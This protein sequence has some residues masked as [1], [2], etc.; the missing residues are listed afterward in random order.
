MAAN[1]KTFDF[2]MR[3]FKVFKGSGSQEHEMLADEESYLKLINNAK[4]FLV[5]LP[6]FG[7]LN[8]FPF[9]QGIPMSP[10]PKYQRCMGIT[11]IQGH[12][13]ILDRFMR[14]GFNVK[15]EKADESCLYEDFQKKPSETKSFFDNFNLADITEGYNK[16]T[17]RR[18]RK[19]V[20]D[21]KNDE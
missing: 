17:E 4:S 10:F 13:Q 20:R 1:F 16:L 19:K 8:K 18:N 9:L 12:M 3:E 5:G 21:L 11:P 14:V 2:N 6:V 15:L 7:F